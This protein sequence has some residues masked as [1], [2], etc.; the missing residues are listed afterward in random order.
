MDH[1]RDGD[2]FAL[3]L[4]PSTWAMLSRGEPVLIEDVYADTT[5]T[6]ESRTVYG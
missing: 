6:A 3:S 5:L 2:R 4:Q 1:V